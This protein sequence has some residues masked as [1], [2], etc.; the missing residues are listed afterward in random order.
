[1]TNNNTLE[2]R[3]R[4]VNEAVLYGENDR[5]IYENYLKPTCKSMAIKKVKNWY[6][7]TRAIQAFYN[8]ANQ[9][10]Q[11]YV[12]EFK[13]YSEYKRWYHFLNKQ[14][15][16]EVAKILLANNSDYIEELANDYMMNK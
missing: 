5:F 12:T 8:V 14:E 15:R 3:E 9:I 1:M 11:R 2:I 4:N 10:A 16:Y 6:D 7:E 13:E